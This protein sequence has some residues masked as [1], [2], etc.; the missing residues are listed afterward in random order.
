MTFWTGKGDHCLVT[1]RLTPNARHDRLDGCQTLADG[2]VVLA[3]RVRSV[4]E[5]GRAN[6][7]LCLLLAQALGLAKSSVSIA[8]GHSQ[9]LKVIRI[10]QD[11]ARIAD[12]LQSLAKV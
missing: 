8:S 1:V 6:D 11:P 10:A 2:R 9:R 12:A 3:A 4:P 7:A 5:D